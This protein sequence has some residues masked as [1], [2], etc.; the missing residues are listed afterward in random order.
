MEVII[1]P[2]REAAADLVARI[3]AR[4]L[5]ANPR[6]FGLFYRDQLRR[7]RQPLPW[8]KALVRT[9]QCAWWARRLP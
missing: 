4:D 2:N 8:I 5:R 7:L 3:I 9:L 6:G 1:Q